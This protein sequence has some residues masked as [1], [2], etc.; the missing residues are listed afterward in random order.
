MSIIGRYAILPMVTLHKGVS[1][2]THQ[3]HPYVLAVMPMVDGEF[4]SYISDLI[5]MQRY[6][7][8]LI[9]MI[10]FIMGNSAK[11]VLMLPEDCIPEGYSV[12]DFAHEYV[13][14]NGIIVYRPNNRGLA[15][16]QIT[17]NSHLPSAR[18]ANAIAYE[19]RCQKYGAMQG[20]GQFGH[21]LRSCSAG[22]CNDL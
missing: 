15:P 17:N 21:P 10:D 12:E 2:F 11:G 4:R 6:V 13:K 3:S 9:T 18:A 8:R 16:T 7:N 14:A 22:V 1:P 5:D 19:R 20:R